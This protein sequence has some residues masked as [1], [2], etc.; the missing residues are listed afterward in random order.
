[1]GVATMRVPTVF[2]AIDRFSSVVD[3]MT[4]R[5]AA[6]GQ[7]AQAAAMRTSRQFNSAGNAMLGAGIG[8]AT[9]LGYA[10]NEAVKFEKAMANVDT[11]IDSTPELIKAMGDSVLEMS[12]RLP[13]PISQLT[14]ALYDVVSAGIASKHSMLVLE[15]SSK[16]AVAG[17]GTAQEGVDVITSSLNA[18]NISASESASVANMVFKAVKYGKT[19]VSG[20]A[21]SFGSSAALI[22]NS[23]VSLT[24]YL[25]TTATLTTTGM[26]ASRAQTQ[27]A[28]AVTA[29]IKPSKAMQAILD[30]LGA[31]S[32]PMFI[33]K[34]GGLVNTMKLVSDRAN[35]MGILTSKAFG[36]KEGFS[37]MLSLL[38]P[39][40]EK[41]LEVM[42]D[43]VG[44]TDSMT[45]AFEKQQKTVS[46]GV[47][48]MKNSMTVLA[49]KIGEELMPR[50]N[51]FI[52]RMT[53]VVDGITGWMK[54][55][56]GL[57]TTLF[58][59]T[60]GL[61]IFGAVAK[62]GAFLFFGLAKIIQFGTF[63][64]ETATAATA[65]YEGVMLTAALSGQGL[66]VVLFE[67]AAAF[68]AAAWPVLLIVA[69]LGLL[70]YAMFDSATATGDLVDKHVGA[71]DRKNAAWQKSTK[72]QE[73]ELQK[74]KQLM[75]T[76]NPDV[77]K[78]AKAGMPMVSD[79]LKRTKAAEI[80]NSKLPKNQQLSHDALMYQIKSGDYNFEDKSIGKPKNLAGSNKSDVQSVMS[81]MNKKGGALTINIKDP[82]KNIESVD[83]SNLSGIPVKTTS[84]KGQR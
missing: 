18:F 10:V 21:E 58:N 29:L 48:R 6:F 84:N 68:L 49:I 47:Q 67:M 52:D 80:Q 33:K 38:G 3:R 41:Y 54:L 83:E 24:E 44:G 16:L 40:K 60:M 26:T 76:H 39:L 43:M 4:R 8:I 12:K 69:A 28:S 20:L 82:G 77:M 56:K 59:I 66:T 9:G 63:V 62:V 61:L 65:L 42:G 53:P 55:N 14:D 36:R 31:K 35:K 72:V 37:A 17:L 74:Q 71:L 73:M 46:A 27:V 19:T 50:V 79:I 34:N 30:S 45:Q 57:A 25:A 22:K 51:D 11:T 64:M 78:G 75:E 5:T 23:N 32:I 15:Q 2:F 13:V 81:A 7:T 70:T 1:M